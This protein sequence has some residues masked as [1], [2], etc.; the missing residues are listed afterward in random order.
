M[1]NERKLLNNKIRAAFLGVKTIVGV[2][3]KKTVSNKLWGS[4]IP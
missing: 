4:K 1:F 2:K 3:K